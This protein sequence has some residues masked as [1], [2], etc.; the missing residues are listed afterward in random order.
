ML[1]KDERITRGTEINRIIRKK[2]F[3]HSSPLLRVIAEENNDNNSRLVVV[4]AKRIGGSVARNRM[5]RVLVG[6]YSRNKHKIGKNMNFVVIPKP[7]PYNNAALE[8]E[9]IDGLK[10]GAK[11]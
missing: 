7:G 9:L 5:K 1:P 2:Q 8:K 11:C 10:I 6:I 3:C 4:C